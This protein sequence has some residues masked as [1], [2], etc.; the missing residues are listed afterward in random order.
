MPAILKRDTF[1]IVSVLC[2]LFLSTFMIPVIPMQDPLA[3]SLTE[4]FSSPSFHHPFGTDELGRD[5]LSRTLSGAATT[6]KVSLFALLSSLFI[7]IIFGGIAGYLYQS[8]VDKMF[9]WI[10]SLIFSL[11]FLLII[12]SVLSVIEANIFNAYLILTLIMWVNPARIVRAEVVR[13]RKQ[14]YVTALRS[15]GASETHILFT[16][17][18][19]VSIQS[20]VIF[21]VGYLP[22]IIG[23]E[24]GLSF[25]GLGVQPPN[26]GLGKMI[27]TGLNYLY[28]SWWISF[29]PAAFLCI[30]VLIIN[31]SF[32]NE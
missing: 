2:L 15:Y 20:A 3:I 4:R 1:K 11:P 22:E 31:R 16:A 13:T 9:N 26:P 10:V 30:I 32:K 8:W 21:S 27:F 6:M 19:P 12:V 17:V 28:S 14:L 7:G 18:L 24:A 25:L 5:L 23:L 29:I